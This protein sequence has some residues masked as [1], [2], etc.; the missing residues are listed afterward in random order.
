MAKWNQV[1]DGNAHVVR[2]YDDA[3]ELGLASDD[4]VRE[5]EAAGPTGA[6]PAYRDA[7][8]VWQYVQPSQV[9]HYRRNLR[10]TVVTVYVEVQS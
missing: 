9:D 2:S 6:V 10:E 1:Q 7:D 3:R 4:L 8:G 5:S